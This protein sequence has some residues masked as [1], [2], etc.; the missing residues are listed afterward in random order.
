MLICSWAYIHSWSS[1]IKD[2][3]NIFFN[4]YWPFRLHVNFDI[5]VFLFSLCLYMFFDAAQIGY[6]YVSVAIIPRIR[7]VWVTAYHNV[8]TKERYRPQRDSNPI[9]PCP[10]LANEPT[11]RHNI[12]TIFIININQSPIL[13]RLCRSL[14]K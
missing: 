6:K 10:E 2:I 7:T 1:I 14:I 5:L 8:V 12:S 4:Y 13:Y 3:I 11:W 9:H